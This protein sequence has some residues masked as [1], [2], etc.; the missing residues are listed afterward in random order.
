[1]PFTCRRILTKYTNL[2]Y[3]VPKDEHHRTNHLRLQAKSISKFVNKI[4]AISNKW[5]TIIKN[6]S[7]QE[8]PDIEN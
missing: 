2:A 7:L 6:C 5:C 1:L 8:L 4:K 3:S